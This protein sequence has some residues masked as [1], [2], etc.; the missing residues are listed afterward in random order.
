MWEPGTRDDWGRSVGVWGG[1]ERETGCGS[2]KVTA[3]ATSAASCITRERENLRSQISQPTP[4]SFTPWSLPVP[5]IWSIWLHPRYR[6][7]SSNV[8]IPKTREWCCPDGT[9]NISSYQNEGTLP[10]Y[11]S[12]L[13]IKLFFW[14]LIDLI[15]ELLGL[16]IKP[17]DNQAES[18]YTSINYLIIQSLDTI[19]CRLRILQESQPAKNRNLSRL[20]SNLSLLNWSC[21]RNCVYCFSTLFTLVQ[22]QEVPQYLSTP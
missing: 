1:E 21:Q 20:I 8:K 2:R 10:C 4:I 11:I 5:S 16:I 19:I 6:T 13:T 9:V 22:Q 12:R 17:F 7:H 14:V 3:A 18:W 15:I